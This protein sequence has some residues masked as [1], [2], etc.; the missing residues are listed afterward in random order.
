M[1]CL[2][3]MLHLPL[4]MGCTQVMCICVWKYTVV[5]RGERPLRRHLGEITM[6]IVVGEA[7]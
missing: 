1:V 3:I 6:P 5:R 4:H 2:H 7:V